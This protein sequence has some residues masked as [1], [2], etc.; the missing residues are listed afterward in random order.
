S[1]G[2]ARFYQKAISAGSI[3]CSGPCSSCAGLI[4]LK[5]S[6]CRDSLQNPGGGLCGGLW[7]RT[8]VPQCD[9]RVLTHATLLS[10]IGTN[11]RNGC[12]LR[13]PGGRPRTHWRGGLAVLQHPYRHPTLHKR[14]STQTRTGSRLPAQPKRT[15][16]GI[17]K[18]TGSRTSALLSCS[19]EGRTYR[20]CGTSCRRASAAVPSMYG[21]I[22]G[23]HVPVR[24]AGLAVWLA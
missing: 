10:P 20:R 19:R 12:R 15:L 3:Q 6:I 23:P 24:R 16:V 9:Y 14:C 7:T 8:P 11:V 18:T 5:S 4:N 17:S 13:Q 21:R 2:H 22:L 1:S